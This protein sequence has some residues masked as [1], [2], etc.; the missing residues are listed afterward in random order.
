M[1][2]SLLQQKS[3][4]HH[5]IPTPSTPSSSGL[6]L[7]TL[8]MRRYLVIY[9]VLLLPSPSASI[10]QGVAPFWVTSCKQYNTHYKLCVQRGWGIVSKIRTTT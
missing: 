3:P 6:A 4:L 8:G 5:G 9:S 1:L 10:P 2:F 7:Q